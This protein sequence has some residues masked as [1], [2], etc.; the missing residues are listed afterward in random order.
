M[1]T[2]TRE[3]N[4]GE[5]CVG[6]EQTGWAALFVRRSVGVV[7][8]RRVTYSVLEMGF[9]REEK[10]ILMA[11]NAKPYRLRIV[12]QSS[13]SCMYPCRC[14]SHDRDMQRAR[15]FLYRQ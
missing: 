8:G 14:T 6:R 11:F 12:L 13:R 5:V 2:S 7:W 1:A 4:R 10:D 3:W 15:R 9:V